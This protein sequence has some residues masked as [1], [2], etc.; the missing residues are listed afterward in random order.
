MVLEAVQRHV[1]VLVLT[2]TA[3]MLLSR[4][5]GAWSSALN[6]LSLRY[7]CI[8][9]RYCNEFALNFSDTLRAWDCPRAPS[10]VD[11]HATSPVLSIPSEHWSR[12]FGYAH[13]TTRRAWVNRSA[14]GLR[15][16]PIDRF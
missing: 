15:G 1:S 7:L 5:S 3:L 6:P 2:L 11:L 13:P 14:L 4:L 9:K 16:R 8:L 10:K 12:L